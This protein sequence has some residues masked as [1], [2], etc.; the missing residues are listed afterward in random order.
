MFQGK[1]TVSVG[2]VEPMLSRLYGVMIGAW[3]LQAPVANRPE[4]DHNEG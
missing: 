4:N 1:P 2:P 3:N